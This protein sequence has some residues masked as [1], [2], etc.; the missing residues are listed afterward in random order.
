[1]TIDKVTMPE[2]TIVGAGV[3]EIGEN[4]PENV[5]RVSAEDFSDAWK[6]W[7]VGDRLENLF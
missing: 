4:V 6:T 1:M 2:R 7:L 3:I 5:E